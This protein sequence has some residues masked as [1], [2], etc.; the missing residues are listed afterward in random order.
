MSIFSRIFGIQNKPDNSSKSNS[1]EII[2]IRE[3]DRKFH[4]L[5]ER[6]AY[7]ARTDYKPLCSEYRDLFEQFLALKKSKTLEFYCSQNDIDLQKIEFFIETFADLNKN[8]ST[9]IITL[10]NKA[11]LE[12]H[13]VSDKSYLDNILK[14]VD[15][16]INL[17]DEQ[18]RVVL[19]DEDYMLVVAGAGAGKTTTVAAKVKYLVE[20]NIS[21]PIRF[22]LFRL[23]TRPLESYALR[24]TKHLKLI[25]QLPRSIK[26]V[27]QS[28]ADRMKIGN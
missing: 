5:L 19:S 15:R 23:R 13:L 24:L 16:S 18:R 21:A 4:E 17:D 28:F 9:E 6:D 12:K 26:R 2:R 20:K 22:L 1:L 10:H 25:A 11:F 8:E 14:K 27:M 7:L 3:F